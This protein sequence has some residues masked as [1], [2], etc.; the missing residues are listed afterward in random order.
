MKQKQQPRWTAD[1]HHEQLFSNRFDELE[2]MNKLFDMY[3]LLSLDH[4][5]INN[6]PNT[7]GESESVVPIFKNLPSSPSQAIFTDES[8]QT[9]STPS[10]AI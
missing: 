9:N 10:E 7:G 4:E 8:Y 5:E 2:D 6:R 1:N 3:S